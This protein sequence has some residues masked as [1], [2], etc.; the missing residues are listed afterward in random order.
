MKKIESMNFTKFAWECFL[1]KMRVFASHKRMMWCV[2]DP[3]RLDV[4]EIKI[5][6]N[7]I[8]PNKIRVLPEQAWTPADVGN[9][10]KRYCAFVGIIT[11]LVRSGERCYTWSEE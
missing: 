6:E 1:V 8:I 4:L 2:I 5:N 9:T 10:K 7:I 3:A 11:P